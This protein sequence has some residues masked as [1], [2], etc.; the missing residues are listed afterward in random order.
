MFDYVIPDDIKQRIPKYFSQAFAGELLGV[1]GPDIAIKDEDD[2]YGLCFL[3]G[4]VGWHEAFKATCDK[5]A[6]QWLY[7]YY[8][9]L[10]WYESDKFDGEME[11]AIIEFF[12]G[13]RDQPSP[14]ILYL[15][16]R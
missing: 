14:Y 3:G 15:M 13:D 16:E 4:T 6:M 11:A 9:A 1:F 12:E 2:V 10:E 8:E 5:L 7:D